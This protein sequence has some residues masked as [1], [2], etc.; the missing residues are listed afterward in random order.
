MENEGSTWTGEALEGK[1]VPT[2]LSWIPRTITPIHFEEEEEQPGVQPPLVDPP[3]INN[4]MGTIV[5]RRDAKLL[6]RPRADN[7]S[8]P[9]IGFNWRGKLSPNLTKCEPEYLQEADTDRT[10]GNIWKIS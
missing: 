6:R 8:F 7:S 4:N 5:N 3:L 1:V 2:S 10:A 9:I